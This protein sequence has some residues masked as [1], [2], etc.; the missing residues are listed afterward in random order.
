MKR[1]GRIS[2]RLFTALVILVAVAVCVS[3]VLSILGLRYTIQRETNQ[4]FSEFSSSV[5]QLVED[6]LE[7]SLNFLESVGINYVY[8]QAAYGSFNMDV[9]Q[10]RAEL[11]DFTHIIILEKDGTG[12]SSDGLSVDYSQNPD[13][14]RALKGER[15]LT[16]AD[17]QHATARGNE[18]LLAVPM[19]EGD[20]IAGAVVACTAPSWTADWALPSF[21]GGNVFFHLIQSDGSYLLRSNSPYVTG[22]IE[23]HAELNQASLFDVLEV[24]AVFQDGA[25]IEQIRAAAAEGRS[26]TVHFSYPEVET[27]SDRVGTLI[28]LEQPGTFLWIAMVEGT[29]SQLYDQFYLWSLL[30]NGIIVLVF[31][32]LS[33]L[34]FVLYRRNYRLAF[35]DPV[36]GGYSSV[37][38]QLEAQKKIRSAPP[39]TYLFISINIDKF[40]A[41]NDLFGVDQ[42]D[43]L[44]KYIYK[45]LI[46]YQS[47]GELV[48]RFFADQ[49]YILAAARPR[50][51][52]TRGFEEILREIAQD[53]KKQNAGREEDLYLLS[54]RI[55]VYLVD[56][57]SLPLTL[58]QDR[59]QMAQKYH[60]AP[61]AD[62]LGVCGFYTEED[63]QQFLR[64]KTV[65]NKM[66]EA[67]AS[68][69]FLPYLQPKV[70]LQS[71]KIA[72][73][74]CLVRWEDPEY[75][76]IFP[77]RFIPI[78]EKNGF[79]YQ[80]DLYL[81]EA[82]CRYLRER[83]DGGKA[84]V[85]I[86]INLSRQVITMRDFL[87]PYIRLQKQYAIPAELLD[88]EL[89]ETMVLEDSHAVIRAVDA[90]HAAGFRCSLDDFGSGYS[91][92]N[93]LREI[94]VDT[95]KL[96]R[97]FLASSDSSDPRERA[98]V[99]T[100]VHLAKQLGME[101]CAEGVETPAQA[102]FLAGIH[103]EK[104][105]GYLYS[106]PVDI[107][108]FDSLLDQGF[109]DAPS[110]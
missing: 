38:F 35:V 42:G 84:V 83:L 30:T 44:L 36:T 60:S 34:L 21:F 65:E 41:I 100:I 99:E 31:I 10:R 3:C 16:L 52:V 12:V 43:M 22:L 55:G 28:P 2:V 1:T 25:T 64:E 88:F 101:C 76:M 75:G 87:R 109:L 77:D 85:P 67:L 71:G 69:R 108:A 61:L 63:R 68:R 80:M 47:P 5:K 27:G 45:F 29:V 8:N 78:F 110:R 82:V 96:D 14:L 18:F 90:I 13:I 106:K 73:A 33:I 51:E 72:G 97:A 58:I 92:L 26:I 104:G 59:A 19:Y 53:R 95:L 56:E 70:D 102:A 49:F 37:R 94:R 48:C 20:A 6:R 40:K 23:E 91:S 17:E 57:P 50:E 66:E 11:M 39:G 24:N 9:L 7:Q 4:Y 32:G 62:H 86:S 74:E 103:C 79:I 54:M 89:T 81:F 93:L 15:V 107:A 46:R 105:Q 98:V